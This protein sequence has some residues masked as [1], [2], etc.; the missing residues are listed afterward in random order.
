MYSF[1]CYLVTYK[2]AFHFKYQKWT[3]HY[4]FNHIFSRIQYL[5]QKTWN[6]V[7][8]CS[9]CSSMTMRV[10]M[11]LLALEDCWSILTGSCL[12]THFTALIS[13]R[14]TTAYLP[15]WRI[16]WDHSA[17]TVMSLWKL[18]KY[19]WSHGRQTLTQAYTN[20]F[21][22]TSISSLT[23]TSLRIRLST[24]AFLYII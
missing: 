4:K 15:T 2:S 8:R 18:S 12:T 3:F 10:R 6:S 20:L 9:L 7:I 19:S 17:W 14:T 5:E 13:L 21:P 23:V 16:G 1:F 11:K 22:D 24:F